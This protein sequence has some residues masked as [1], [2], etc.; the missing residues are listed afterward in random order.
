MH[1]KNF[2]IES[3]LKREW[4]Y[5]DKDFSRLEK[6]LKM[7]FQSLIQGRFMVRI[8]EKR[9]FQPGINV[10][11]M[12][13]IFFKRKKKFKIFLDFRIIMC[14]EFLFSIL[15][16]ILFVLCEKFFS[17]IFLKRVRFE[18]QTYGKELKRKPWLENTKK[19]KFFVFNFFTKV[20]KQI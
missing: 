11:S 20:K 4:K 13:L 19:R 1:Y 16:I 15:F 10:K 5:I 6:T 9:F 2:D 8:L 18:L 17:E 3:T 12:P 14:K 7:C